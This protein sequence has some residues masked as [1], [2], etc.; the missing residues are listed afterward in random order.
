MRV[1]LLP[2]GVGKPSDGDAMAASPS[3]DR[4]MRLPEL[5]VAGAPRCGTTW[6]YRLLDRHPKIEMAKPPRPEPKFF[7]DDALYARGLQYYSQTWFAGIG[8]DKVAGEKS[9]NYLENAVVAERLGRDLPHVQLVFILRNPIERAFSN[10]RWSRMNGLETEDFA[11]ALALEAERE[12]SVIDAHKIA[13]PHAYF[14][15]GL[16]QQM[17]EPYFE[18]FPR[19][20]ILCL[21]FEDI[22][23]RPKVLA[24]RVHRFLSI[25]P[26]SQDVE[27]LGRVNASRVSGI[28][29]L[30]PAVR[31]WLDE[32][33]E[34]PNRQLGELLGADFKLW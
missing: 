30:P 13:R 23:G 20:Q 18:R 15:R 6:L 28:A 17:L 33:Y 31:Q 2:T 11:T 5:I 1:G 12:R 14:S 27:G 16:Y 29:D 9:T 32:R 26:R 7:L 22:L 8:W 4:G 3:L 10:Y 34:L 19:E 25:D 21:K 24:E